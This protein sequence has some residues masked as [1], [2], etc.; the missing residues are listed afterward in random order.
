MWFH[1]CLQSRLH[2]YSVSE[3]SDI[4]FLANAGKQLKYNTLTG[5]KKENI[6]LIL[7]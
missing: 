2:Q 5:K 4:V 6:I 1:L 3:N 7:L